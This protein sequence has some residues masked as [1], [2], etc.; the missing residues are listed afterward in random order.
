MILLISGCT[1][2]GKM[3]LSQKLLEEF[4]YPYYSLDHLK[5]G[6]IL[7]HKTNKTTKDNV[8]SWTQEL[9]PITK[10]IIHIA[11][12]NHQNLIVEGSYLPF[13]YKKDF[14]L[15][16]NK[17]FKYLCLLF[18]EDYLQTHFDSIL[19]YESVV[20]KRLHPNDVSLIELIQENRLFLSETLK[21]ALPF[22]K[23]KN[24]YDINEIM[25]IIQ[26][27]ISN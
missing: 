20:E 8:S 16:E 7:S 21:Y 24:K 13:D 19:S 9:W 5:M 4:H 25:D 26:R 27:E 1:H 14:S 10:A 3:N 15:E 2:S 23:I 17:Q 18:D 12:E 6:L 11:I 22:Y